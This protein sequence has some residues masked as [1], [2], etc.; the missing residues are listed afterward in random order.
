MQVQFLCLLFIL[1][2]KDNEMG[3]FFLVPLESFTEHAIKLFMFAS[4]HF[5]TS[6][7]VLSCPLPRFHS[8][9]GLFYSTPTL[10]FIVNATKMNAFLFQ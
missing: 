1:M 6:E 7:T 3:V 2:T 10:D 8:I 5:S 4:L 9:S